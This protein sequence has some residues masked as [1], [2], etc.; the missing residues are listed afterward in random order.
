[1]S[2]AVRAAE[3]SIKAIFIFGILSIIFSFSSIFG[4]GLVWLDKTYDAMWLYVWIST[5]FLLLLMVSASSLLVIAE[6]KQN[7][8]EK[9]KSHFLKEKRALGNSQWF[10]V[11]VTLF[12]VLS[13]IAFSL[14]LH[15]GESLG[16]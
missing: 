16:R 6:P 2:K 14:A 3:L 11:F 13:A 4:S 12:T 7:A 9:M 15:S 1:M 8:E 10:L 5:G